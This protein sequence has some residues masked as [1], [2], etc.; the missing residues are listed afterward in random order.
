MPARTPNEIKSEA[1]SLLNSN[2]S[3][4]ISILVDRVIVEVI[5]YIWLRSENNPSSIGRATFQM[6]DIDNAH[7]YSPSI[8]TDFGISDFRSA[9]H[10]YIRDP[11]LTLER[12]I[13][14]HYTFRPLEAFYTTIDV[15]PASSIFSDSSA[16]YN[17]RYASNG[18]YTIDYTQNPLGNL[19]IS[20]VT[21]LQILTLFYAKQLPNDLDFSA[22]CPIMPDFD[23]LILQGVHALAS[24]WIQEP[25]SIVSSDMILDRALKEGLDNY[26]R[27]LSTLASVEM[28]TL[29]VPQWKRN[30]RRF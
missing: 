15:N 14:R 10:L 26:K 13:G 8:N 18:I 29:A 24:R 7:L 2:G 25:E 11:S 4:E 1:L 12:G 23:S 27:H 16:Y 6:P 22:P 3:G 30:Y 5:R 20:P 17:S 28:V 9:R 21:R 19:Y